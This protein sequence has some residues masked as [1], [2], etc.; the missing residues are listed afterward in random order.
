MKNL[1]GKPVYVHHGRFDSDIPLQ[2]G[3]DV[4][5]FF[6]YFGASG[7]L[8]VTEYD[9]VVPTVHERCEATNEN[10]FRNCGYDST[11][12]MLKH[13][14]RNIPY[15]FI[16]QLKPMDKDWKQKGVLRKF[17]QKMLLESFIW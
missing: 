16:N 10:D 9:H 1:R 15:G 8:D 17:S 4:F 3:I 13:L 2:R 14:L 5:S 6:K 12:E 11:G 7:K